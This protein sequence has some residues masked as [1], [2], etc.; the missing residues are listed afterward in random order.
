ME[1]LHCYAETYDG[2]VRL[3]IR[4]ENNEEHG[5]IS[6]WENDDYRDDICLFEELIG[7]YGE[8][9]YDTKRDFKT[10]NKKKFLDYFNIV[11]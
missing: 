9:Y 1:E 2:L 5:E 10:G 8:F 4:R 7:E 6:V 11:N 3:D